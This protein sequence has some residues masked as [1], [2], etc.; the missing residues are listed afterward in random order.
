M[1][2]NVEPLNWK[3]KGLM[4]EKLQKIASSKI[5]KFYILLGNFESLLKF[6]THVSFAFSILMCQNFK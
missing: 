1:Y 3:I 4:K 2:K 6:L 5:S